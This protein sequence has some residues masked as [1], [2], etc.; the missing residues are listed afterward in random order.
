MPQTCCQHE[1]STRGHL[2]LPELTKHTVTPQTPKGTTACNINRCQKSKTPSKEKM[3]PKNSKRKKYLQ[4]AFC[5]EC[6]STYSAGKRFLTS[7]CPFM[8]LQS[9]GRRKCFPTRVAVVLFWSSSGESREQH[10]GRGRG[11]WP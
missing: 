10:R 4:I 11:Q 2:G 7:V 9:T 6:S 1:H 8:D 3:K 5:C